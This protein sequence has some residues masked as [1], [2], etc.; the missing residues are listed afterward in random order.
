MRIAICD[1]DEVFRDDFKGLLIRMLLDF[2]AE[3]DVHEFANG[4]S[5]IHI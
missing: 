4:L 5:L 2:G 1:D 3:C